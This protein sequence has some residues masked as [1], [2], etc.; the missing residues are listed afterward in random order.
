[1]HDLPQFHRDNDF[2]TGALIPLRLHPS[3]SNHYR[4]TIRNLSS[5]H[6]GPGLKMEAT[7]A[8]RGLISEIRMMRDAEALG[9]HHT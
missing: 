8:L 2:W 5:D 4:S 9:G 3:L 7:E 6:Q 1:M